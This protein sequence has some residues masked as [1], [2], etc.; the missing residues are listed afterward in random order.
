MIHNA[1]KALQLVERMA[2]RPALTHKY[3]LPS[4]VL[5]QLQR[6]GIAQPHLAEARKNVVRRDQF[7]GDPISEDAELGV[8][9]SAL[10]MGK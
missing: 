6:H 7:L 10:L 2:F 4:A 5:Q 3:P 1:E 8:S 9:P